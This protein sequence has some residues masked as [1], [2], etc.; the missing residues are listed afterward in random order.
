MILPTIIQARFVPKIRK[1][2]FSGKKTRKIR[3]KCYFKSFIYK[4]PIQGLTVSVD[5]K[6][7]VIVA[8]ILSNSYIES[9]RLLRPGDIILE[10]NGIRIQNPEQVDIQTLSQNH[11]QIDMLILFLQKMGRGVIIVQKWVQVQD[12]QQNFCQRIF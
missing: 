3:E 8:R 10:A 6:G 1:T 7:K 2:F 5:D 9:Q 4:S 11:E 12:K